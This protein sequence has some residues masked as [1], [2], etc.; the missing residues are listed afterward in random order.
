VGR[1][2]RVED[3]A[4]VEGVQ[5]GVASGALPDGRL[6]ETTEALIAAFQ[7]Y[8]RERVEPVLDA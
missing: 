7:A 3:V 4:L 5:A 8:V 2:G 6:L 1:P